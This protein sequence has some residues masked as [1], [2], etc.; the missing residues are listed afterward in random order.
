MG[1]SSIG[2]NAN[3]LDNGVFF[4]SFRW[5]FTIYHLL[6]FSLLCIFL[7][8]GFSLGLV[9]WRYSCSSSLFFVMFVFVLG[10]IESGIAC[11][12]QLGRNR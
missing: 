5:R 9:L 11:Y 2:L 3:I 1:N 10:F 12:K 6:C 4:S 7:Q 8:L